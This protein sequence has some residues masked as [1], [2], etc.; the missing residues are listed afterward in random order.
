MNTTYVEN[1]TSSCNYLILTLADA[2]LDSNQFVRCA[3]EQNQ[4]FE[5]KK[6]LCAFLFH[7]IICILYTG[8][9]HLLNSIRNE[10]TLLL[11]VSTCRH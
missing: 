11:D 7:R 4:F 10:P 8:F 2:K 6:M 9:A 3:R 1:A 5:D